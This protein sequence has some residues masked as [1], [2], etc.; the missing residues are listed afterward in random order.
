MKIPLQKPIFTNSQDKLSNTDLSDKLIEI[1]YEKLLDLS[2]FRYD[3][4]THRLLTT[5]VLLVKEYDFDSVIETIKDDDRLREVHD[6]LNEIYKVSGNFDLNSNNYLQ[7]N[8]Y[9]TWHDSSRF[10]TD[11]LN[12]EMQSKEILLKLFD[13]YDWMGVLKWG[14]HNLFTT[15]STLFLEDYND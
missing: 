14:N 10:Y 9:N 7:A 4:Y 8:H 11:Y 1:L 3:L 5:A 15:D 13:L 6:Y 12:D 2:G